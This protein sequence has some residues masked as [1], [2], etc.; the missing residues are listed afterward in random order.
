ML[1]PWRLDAQRVAV[2]LAFSE[3][4][5]ELDPA[6]AG[7]KRLGPSPLYANDWSPDGRFLLCTD[8]NGE[9]W[10][11][12]RADGSQQIERLGTPG[13][14]GLDLRFAPDG[15]HVAFTTSETGVPQVVVSSFPSFSESHQVS[16]DGQPTSRPVVCSTTRTGLCALAAGC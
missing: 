2:N 10:T 3:G 8:I 4:I 11:L 15:K 9:H 16:I 13:S 6:S 7:S 5:L 1:G 14:E 12:L